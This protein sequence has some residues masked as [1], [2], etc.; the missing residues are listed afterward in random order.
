MIATLYDA[1][2]LPLR[3]SEFTSTQ[4]DFVPVAMIAVALAL[5]LWGVRRNNV[6]HPR[7]RWAVGKT[8]AFLGALITTGIAIFSFV[9]VYDGELFWDHMVQHILLIMVAAPLFAISSPLDLAWR[10]TTGTAHIVVTG[11]L[12]STVAKFFGHPAVAFVFY[13]VL[14]PITHLTVWYNY[15]L[16]HESV[17][18]AEHLAFLVVGYLF[19]RQIFGSDPNCYRLH[20]ALQ[21]F[22]LFLAIPIDTFTG[23]V[24][25]GGLPRD[26]PGLLRHPPDLGPLLRR[27]S[28]RG[29]RHHVGRRRHL[30]ALA[31]DPRGAAL[32]AHGR[33]Q[34]GTHRP[35]TRCLDRRSSSIGG[36]SLSDAL[37][38]RHDRPVAAESSA[39]HGCR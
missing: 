17:H 10:A 1:P 9:G 32:D 24:A 7:H 12:R 18:N 21:F 3:G 13:A 23:L 37:Y 26:V 4:F 8:V 34:G 6:L 2:L 22:Y 30:D 33:A 31:H 5:Y 29:R 28:P 38:D 16:T 39:G 15:T 27:R 14:I 19:W 20:P 11:A 36:R 35:R 25:G